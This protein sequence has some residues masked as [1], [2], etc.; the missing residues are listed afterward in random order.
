[1]IDI[2]R[3]WD[4]IECSAAIGRIP[5]GGLRRLALTD[6]DRDMRRT[7]L[8][9][10][11]A[12]GLET[13]IDRVGNLFARR[14]G[15]E[16]DAPVVMGSHLDTQINGGRFDGV[17]GVLG[18]LEVMR[19]LD[20]HSVRTVRPIELVS[21]TDEEG[22]RFRTGMLGSSVFT[23]ALGLDDALG[24]TDVEAVTVGDELERI[25]FAGDAEVPGGPIHAYLELHIEQ[26]AV[27][28]ASDIDVG[29][30]DRA[31][32]VYYF[33]VSLRG[34]TAHSGPTPMAR[35]R[36]ALLA[37]AHAIVAVDRIARR[38][39]PG[40]KANTSTIS[41]WPNRSGI[42]PS[43]VDIRVDFRHPDA[44]ALARM[45][46]EVESAL[47]AAAREANVAIQ[48]G[49]PVRYGGNAFD[50]RCMAAIERAAARR[51]IQ[52]IR[53]AT[54]AAHDA[55]VIGRRYPAAMIFCPC[56]DGVSHNPAE[57]AEKHRVQASVNVLLDAVVELAGA[58]P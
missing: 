57:D 40:G 13:R 30:V 37:A 21:W 48:L 56:R 8:T 47:R 36:N 19:A 26:D 58:Q 18:G 20:E 54:Q 53:M 24:R 52:T 27:L 32:G 6:P 51:G 25:G 28:D 41:V 43:D 35:R 29:V 9:W 16:D 55:M 5:G 46:D 22:A 4:S 14:A 50:A 11:R 33:D 12:L 2:D 15:L 42:V 49:D 1:M 39:Q 31:Y 3:L 44:T 17:L 38:H 10:C 7:F 45:R 34:E 23:G